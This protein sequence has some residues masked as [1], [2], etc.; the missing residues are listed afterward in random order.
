MCRYK[1]CVLY[2][3]YPVQ[4]RYAARNPCIVVYTL[5]DIVHADGLA[6]CLQVISSCPNPFVREDDG[7]SMRSLVR[8][9]FH[10]MIEALGEPQPQL[11]LYLVLIP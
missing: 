9:S 2:T 11:V 7:R 1:P 8:D 3:P 4:G 6:A 5:R 10:G